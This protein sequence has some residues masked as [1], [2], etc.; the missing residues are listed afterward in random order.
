LFFAISSK[1][2]WVAIRGLF[3]DKACTLLTTHAKLM[4]SENRI[5]SVEQAEFAGVVAVSD[6]PLSGAAEP[7]RLKFIMKGG[8]VIKND[9]H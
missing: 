2:H 6:G 8:Q 1:D 5:G 9:F 7:G 3:D 4:A